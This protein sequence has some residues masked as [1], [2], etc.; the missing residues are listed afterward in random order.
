[1]GAFWQLHIFGQRR[2]CAILASNPHRQELCAMPLMLTDAERAML[3]ALA[4]PIDANRRPEFMGAVTKQLEAAGPAAVGPGALHRTA[5]EVLGQFW[6]APP[7][8]RQNRVGPRGPR[9][10]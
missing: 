3:E 1:M 9:N 4:A 6:T 2:T 8:L 5:R 7:D 10:A